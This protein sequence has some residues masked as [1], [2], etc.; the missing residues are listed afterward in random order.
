[1]D[2][3]T[4]LKSNRSWALG[5]VALGEGGYLVCILVNM[6]HPLIMLQY[7]MWVEPSPYFANSPPLLLHIMSMDSFRDN[8]L[9][10]SDRS[11]F[12]Y[13]SKSLS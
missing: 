9:V 7:N 6:R 11:S 4:N 12:L 8:N 5:G 10:S 13:Y 3:I 1:M 2:S